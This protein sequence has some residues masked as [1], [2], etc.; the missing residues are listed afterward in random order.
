MKF[1]KLT[2]LPTSCREILAA[3]RAFVDVTRPRVE[4]V[5]SGNGEAARDE[6]LEPAQVG[7]A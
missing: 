6:V 2:P 5:L 4:D 7:G 1:A 3:A